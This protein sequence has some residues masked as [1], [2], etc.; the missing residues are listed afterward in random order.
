LKLCPFSSLLFLL[1]LSAF[2]LSLMIIRISSLI[3]MIPPHF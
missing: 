1:L 2:S 3:I